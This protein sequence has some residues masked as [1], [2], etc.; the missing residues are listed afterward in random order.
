MTPPVLGQVKLTGRYSPV[1]SSSRAMVVESLRS[2]V[3]VRF[4]GMV[5]VAL[6]VIG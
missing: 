6:G 1:E 4:Q 3:I 2:A 5:M